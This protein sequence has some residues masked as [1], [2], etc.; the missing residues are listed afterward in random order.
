MPEEDSGEV[1]TWKAW[2][3]L[4]PPRQQLCWQN[5]SGVPILEILNLLEACN[6]QGKT[7]RENYS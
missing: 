5:L 3:T 1:A 6:F 4:S 7:W 2:E